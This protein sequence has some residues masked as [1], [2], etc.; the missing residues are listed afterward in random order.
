MDGHA[1]F[2]LMW[3]PIFDFSTTSEVPDISYKGLCSIGQGIN[4]KNIHI[5]Q[6]Y[7]VCHNILASI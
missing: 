4:G 2:S 1:W 6:E 5:G 7:W 3:M